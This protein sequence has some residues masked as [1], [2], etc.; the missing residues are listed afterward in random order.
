MGWRCI[1]VLVRPRTLALLDD[2]NAGTTP[3]GHQP[4]KVAAQM[5]H[6]RRP[7]LP[8]CNLCTSE[9]I[10]EP[11]VLPQQGLP[12]L[13]SLEM[14]HQQD[15]SWREEHTRVPVHLNEN[16][17][18]HQQLNKP[19]NHFSLGKHC[20]IEYQHEQLLTSSAVHCVWPEYFEGISFYELRLMRL[21]VSAYPL[22]D[23][24]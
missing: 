12:G 10:I 2:E 24:R 7:F 9:V 21:N 11:D 8:L 19:G 23:W 20:N 18:H 6:E 4:W 15:N 3:V 16:W 22:L 17:S 14:L 1:C 13:E 5:S